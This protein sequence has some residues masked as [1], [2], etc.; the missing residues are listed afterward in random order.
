[1]EIPLYLAMT[2]LEFRQCRS[3]PPNVGW[4]SCLF[5][6]YGR[7]LSNIPKAL[8]SGSLLILS[9]RTPICGHDPE[10]IFD[11]LNHTLSTF[12]CSGL[13][14]DFER[15]NNQE[16][17]DLVRKLT[18]LPHP[19]AASAVY[20]QGLDCAVFVPSP[21]PNLPLECCLSPWSDREIWLEVSTQ[22]Q[23]ITITADGSESH[24]DEIFEPLPYLDIDLRCHYQI[25]VSETDVC[26]TLRRTQEDWEELL[27]SGSV[28]IRRAIGLHQE[29]VHNPRSTPAP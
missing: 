13:L 6:P 19:V 8:P 10:L 17:A 27:H 28:P 26:F 23:I 5:S 24:T 12:S 14:L 11:M 22:P 16:A 2:A 25:Y 7:G 4:L 1:M 9:D 29:F 20:A 21:L 15:P 18:Q 3:L